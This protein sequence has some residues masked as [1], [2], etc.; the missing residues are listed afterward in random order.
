MKSMT[1]YGKAVAQKDGRTVTIELKSVN[2]RYLDILSRLPK[3]MAAYDDI[4]KRAIQKN[5]VR[6]TFEVFLTYVNLSDT[7]RAVR[8]DMNL[9]QSYIDASKQLRDKF[10]LDADFPTVALMR[11][12]EVITIDVASD[13]EKIVAELVE[14]SANEAMKQLNIMRETEGKGICTDLQHLIDNLLALLQKAVKRAPKVVEDY[15]EKFTKRIKDLACIDDVDSSR[16]LTEI[17]I[18]A[19]KTDVNEEIQRLTSHIEQFAKMLL[20]KEAV[21]RKLDFL[22]QEM[23]RE[24]NTLGSKSNDVELTSYVVKMKNEVEKIKE[25]IR[26]VE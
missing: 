4:I 13:D 19:D 5:A 16:L 21:G 26:N 7:A 18:F 15:K 25:Q 6:G 24:I 9:A 12:P 1:G 14:K 23:V 2:N 3:G 22:S 11:M 20:D 10:C 17:A 8:V